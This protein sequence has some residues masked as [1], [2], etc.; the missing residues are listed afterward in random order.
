MIIDGDDPIKNNFFHE[1]KSKNNSENEHH[2]GH[3]DDD[4]EIILLPINGLLDRLNEYCN[5]GTIVDSRVFAFAIGLKKGEKLSENVS[6][7]ENI[8][9]A[10]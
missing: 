5:N 4:I 2:N 7:P 9:I 10:I 1:K 8:E 3:N 6:Q